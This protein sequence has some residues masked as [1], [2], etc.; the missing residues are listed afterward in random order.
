MPRD[1]TTKS[2][3][4]VAAQ[5]RFLIIIESVFVLA[6]ESSTRSS[7][8]QPAFALVMQTHLSSSTSHLKESVASFVMVLERLWPLMLPHVNVKMEP[9][10]KKEAPLNATAPLAINSP[11]MAV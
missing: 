1:T 2:A 9:S 5:V 10:S 4:P 11:Q 8:R 6:T 7:M 3:L